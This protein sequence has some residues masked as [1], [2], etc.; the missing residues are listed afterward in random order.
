MGKVATP[1]SVFAARWREEVL[2]HEKASTV[3]TMKGHINNSLVPAFGRL[4]VGDIDSE[5]VQSFL[6][7]QGGHFSPKTIKNIWTTL[8]VMWNSAI[9]WKY[10]TGDFRVELPKGRRLRARC[11][12]ANEV[13]RILAHTKGS[14]QVFFWLAA[15]TGL[16]ALIALRVSD[17]DVE[18][19]SIE[20]SKAIWNGT[21]D[22][23]YAR[24]VITSAY[25]PVS[26]RV[27]TDSGRIPNLTVDSFLGR[28]PENLIK[29][30]LVHSQNLMDL[31]AAQLRYDVAYRREWREKAGLGFDLG[32]LGYKSEAPIRPSLVA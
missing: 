16:R 12:T 2:L 31:Y 23:Q 19:L 1:F 7:R 27:R 26:Y 9:A 11:Y 4:A 32:E 14:E 24:N 28:V 10:V 30:W 21:E 15:E 29:L 17:V 18:Q 3:A 5:R 6:N 8:R 13:K 25:V 20:V 22:E